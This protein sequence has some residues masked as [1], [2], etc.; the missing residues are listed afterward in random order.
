M[1]TG[2]IMDNAPCGYLVI[3]ERGGVI[4]IDNTLKNWLKYSDEEK[5]AKGLSIYN[6]LTI[7]SKMYCETHF[8]PM[9]QFKGHVKEINLELLKKTGETQPLLVNA[10]FHRNNNGIKEY[11]CILIDITHRKLYEKELLLA[12]QQSESHLKEL[13]EINEGLS[14]FSHTVAHDLKSPLKN[15]LGLLQLVDNNEIAS[16]KEYLSIAYDQGQEMVEMID[17]L[18][19]FASSGNKNQPFEPVLTNSMFESLN[20]KLEML[21]QKEDVK[22]HCPK[23]NFT[24]TG[25]LSELVRLF[26]NLVENAIKYKKWGISPEIHISITQTSDNIIFSVA[27]NGLG[28]PT[29]YKKSIF[30]PFV[31]VHKDYTSIKGSGIGLATCKKIVSA[32]QGEIWVESEVDKGSTF[33]IS[34]PL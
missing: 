24:I 5:N 6:F 10:N 27:D 22:L 14:Q 1:I 4:Q 33:F 25:N 9:L 30:N 18:L 15:I 20:N 26:Q 12:K 16:S 17:E 23:T 7:G 2:D 21:L 8:F 13:Q 32:H 3:D 28:I 11:V 31:R 19:A 34:L 29:Q